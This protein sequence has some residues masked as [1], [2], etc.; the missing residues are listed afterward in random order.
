MHQTFHALNASG[1]PCPL[2]PFAAVI[3]N[4][5]SP[6][7]NADKPGSDLDIGEVICTG[8][9]QGRQTG[10]MMLHGEI[11]AI[12]NC[13]AILQDPTGK[14]RL[15]PAETIEAFKDLS[16]YTNAESCPMCASATR[17]NGFKEYIYG[18]S[19]DR[20]VEYGFA[21]ITISSEEVFAQAEGLSSDTAL[22]GGV[23]AEET[24]RLFAWQ[25]QDGECPVGCSRAE[26]G[27]GRC[28]PV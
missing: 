28:Q 27:L 15:S 2:Y 3:V 20:L 25:F 4:H 23:L 26:D 8:V 1:S 5:T 17:W 18:T 14:H 24:D 7:N 13:T 6:N 19:I 22:L 10:N 9:N 12:L 16:L 21:Q 11:S